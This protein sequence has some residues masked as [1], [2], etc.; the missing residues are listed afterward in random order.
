MKVKTKTNTQRTIGII[1]GILLI[2]APVAGVLGIVNLYQITRSPDLL[3]ELGFNPNDFSFGFAEW[4]KCSFHIIGFLILIAYLLFILL[5][6]PTPTLVGFCLCAL[7]FLIIA[8]GNITDLSPEEKR[9]GLTAGAW[10][11]EIGT[12]SL[13]YMI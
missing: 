3:R 2:F 4:L 1:S 5:K 13:K 9:R 11:F 7:Y 8:L 10:A 6:K 12:W